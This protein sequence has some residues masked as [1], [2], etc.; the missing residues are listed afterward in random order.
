MKLAVVG[1]GAIGSTVAE[2]AESYG[3]TV[4]ALADSNSAVVD[5]GGVDVSGALVR[6]R[7]SGTLGDGDT[8]AALY[9]GYDCLVETTPTTLDDAE[10]S[11]SHV[12]T[13]LER[14]RHVVL[15]N[16]SPVAQRCRELDA[17]GE[18]SDG[19][20]RFEATIGGPL[21]VLS[22]I[23]DVGPERIDGVRGVFNGLANFIL[24]RMSAEG[25]G[26]E[27]VLAEAQDLGIAE[28]DPTFDVEGTDTALTCSILANVLAT[29]GEEY[30]VDD[31]DIE[32]ITEIP[33]SALELAKEDGMTVRLLGEV[34]G[35]R[36]TVA[37]RTVPTNSPLAV[38]G[39][40]TVVELDIHN[41]GPMNVSSSTATSREVANAILT[42][43][44]RLDRR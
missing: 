41:A 9:A 43:V 33:G 38:T 21:P 42:D 8:E 15:G 19:E 13:A 35:D 17:L 4:T 28:V 7:E 5:E 31:V 39:S 2:F 10:P 26:Y 32:G 14:G 29:G 27:H 11:F 40:Q 37:P 30:T 1:A 25:L 3:H 24:S 23:R 16:K 34:S 6:K 44:N 12:A 36:L 18:E 20:V 22:T